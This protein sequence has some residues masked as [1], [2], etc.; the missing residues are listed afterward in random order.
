[1]IDLHCHLLPGLDDG[2]ADE[3]VALAMARAFLDQG[4][5]IVA[6]TPH[7][8]PG[9]YCNSG[10][11]IRRAVA[12]FQAL[13]DREH[14]GLRVLAGADNHIV[15]DFVTQLRSGHLLT[16]NDTR[17][18]LVEPPHHVAPARLEAFFGEIL[19]A[20]F[21]P[22]LT[23]PERLSWIGRHHHLIGRLVDSGVLLQMTAGSLT[24]RFG[25][26]PRYW[27][28]RLLDDG[29]VHILASDAH[30]MKQR[31]PDLAR[32]HDLAAE[33]VGEAEALNLVANRPLGILE[34]CAAADLPA[35]VHG[36]CGGHD[37][38]VSAHDRQRT[39]A[40]IQNGSG[41][42]AVSGRLRRLLAG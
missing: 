34:N 39:T 40:T 1:M 18:V 22:I 32:G 41:W 7:I 15:P 35:P 33:R 20:G 8:L 17:Y 3:G 25:R 21:V 2:A 5:Q 30:D 12:A 37:G 19:H 10:P 42:N 38:N 31:P 9:L 36:D 14:L 16:L 27:A 29:R 23:H 24:G 13:L 11:A 28:E 26:E 4:V 6:C